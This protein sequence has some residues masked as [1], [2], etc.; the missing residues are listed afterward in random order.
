MFALLAPIRSGELFALLL[1]EW[2]N[3]SFLGHELSDESW[4]AFLS[5]ALTDV[6]SLQLMR[7]TVI[8]CLRPFSPLCSLQLVDAAD[9]ARVREWY[10]LPVSFRPYG[11]G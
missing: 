6:Q 8:K 10:L 11:S 9:F 4:R 2:V 5:P 7:S 1:G 3:A